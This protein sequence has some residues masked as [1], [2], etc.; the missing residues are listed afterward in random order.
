MFLNLLNDAIVGARPAHDKRARLRRFR[1]AAAPCTVAGTKNL[2][3]GV[4]LDSWLQ[5]WFFDAI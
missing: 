2:R 3:D 1:E 4:Q 5:R